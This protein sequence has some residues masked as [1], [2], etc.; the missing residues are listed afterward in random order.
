MVP[1]TMES[2]WSIHARHELDGTTSGYLKKV[3]VTP[4]VY[5]RLLKFL[6]VD[7]QSTWQKSQRI[8]A[9]WPPHCVF[10][11]NQSDSPCMPQFKAS[12]STYQ[13]SARAHAI[14]GK[15]NRVHA[16]G[17][18]RSRHAATTQPQHIGMG[19]DAQPSAPILFP[20][21]RMHVAGFPYLHCPHTRGD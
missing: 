16:H 7:I 9:A 10:L 1:G 13:N 6:Y 8:I 19:P 11:I 3:I 15:P 18:T 12:C 21:L 20:R 2:H 4:T 14:P 17:I 5:P